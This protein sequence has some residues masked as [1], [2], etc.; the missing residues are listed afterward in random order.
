VISL[1]T[2]LTRAW[3]ATYT[4]GLPSKLQAE[5]REEID[6]DLWE[7]QRLADLE[8]KPVTG[9]A[10][11]ILLRLILGIPSDIVWRIETGA[12]AR[13]ERGTSMNESIVM[14]GLLLLALAVAAF[15]LV[16]GVLVVIGANGEM[17]DTERLLFGPLQ[18]VVGLI[19]LS[20]LLLSA[21]SPGLALGLVIAGTIAI[22]AMWYWAAVITLP[23]GLVL[24]AIAYVRGRPAGWPRRPQPV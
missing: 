12:I 1:A 23:V 2:A 10:A 17:S 20:G 7:H 13:S 16:I 5:R 22:S 14:R 18:V 9:I 8:R 4:R 15:P 3:T 6:C 21:R 19:I 24:V 11:E